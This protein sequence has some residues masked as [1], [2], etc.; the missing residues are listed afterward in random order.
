GRRPVA[1]EGDREP[2]GPRRTRDR[3]R[4]AACL[5]SAGR[6]GAVAIGGPAHADGVHHPPDRSRGTARHAGADDAR[7]ER[8]SV[9]GAG[10]A[11]RCGPAGM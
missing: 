4:R 5:P 11:R 8:R 3:P 7:A 2:G 9:G 6:T 1:G 10:R